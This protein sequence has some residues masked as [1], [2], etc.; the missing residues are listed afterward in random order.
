[1]EIQVKPSARFP[2]WLVG[3]EY[4]GQTTEMDY[5]KILANPSV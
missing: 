2:W 5:S 3:E 1:M 4:S